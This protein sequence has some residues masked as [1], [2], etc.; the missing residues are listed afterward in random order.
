MTFDVE[1]GTPIVCTLEGSA[2]GGPEGMAFSGALGTALDAVQK[3][4]DVVVDLSGVDIMNSSGLGMLV[5]ASRTV[6][7]AGGTL[8]LA[9]ANETLQKLLKMTRL[10]TVFAQHS[11]RQEAIE[12]LRSR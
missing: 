10:D 2:L 9:G 5:A 8:A 6:G 1:Q 11:T 7:A 4:A 3:G 12:S